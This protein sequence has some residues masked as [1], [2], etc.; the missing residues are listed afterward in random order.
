MYRGDSCAIG[1]HVDLGAA[2]KWQPPF[3]DMTSTFKRHS[4]KAIN[5]AVALVNAPRRTAAFDVISA[6]SALISSSA[7]RDI[8]TNRRLR[9]AR[10]E[11][12]VEVERHT[13]TAPKFSKDGKVAVLRISSAAQVHP[14][15]ATRWAGHL[16][17][18]ALEIVMCVFCPRPL[19]LSLDLCRLLHTPMRTSDILTRPF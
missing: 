11:I 15:I 6:W 9:E 4:R 14:V 13:H 1:T 18:G 10:A 19:L 7:P 8:L 5:E 2:L 17:S 12:G 16:K 3:P